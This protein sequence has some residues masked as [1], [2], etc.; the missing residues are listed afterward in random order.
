MYFR[1]GST[2]SF[3]YPKA[4]FK[5]CTPIPSG[6]SNA[7]AAS[8]LQQILRE[9]VRGLAYECYNQTHLS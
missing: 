5:G 3:K 9:V 8:G 1:A 6:S 7:P 4:N 2:R